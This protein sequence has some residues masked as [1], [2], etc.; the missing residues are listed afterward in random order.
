MQINNDHFDKK[1]NEISSDYDTGYVVE[2]SK[3][4]HK[5]ASLQCG[6]CKICH[7]TFMITSTCVIRKHGVGLICA[8]TDQ[9]LSCI[10]LINVA[11]SPR[12][13]N[14]SDFGKAALAVAS[15]LTRLLLSVVSD[16]SALDAWLALLTFAKSVLR[17]PN[18]STEKSSP[19]NSSI[20][21][22]IKEASL[23]HPN[24]SL[25]SPCTSVIK[26]QKSRILL[27]N[28]TDNCIVE[29]LCRRVSENIEDGDVRGASRTI[30][31]T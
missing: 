17:L 28:S 11:P 3:R 13:V 27:N 20:A 29:S 12:P 7:W 16:S 10:V 15:S 18:D 24:V 4:V 1:T 30:R 23:L 9:P 25:K 31:S 19:V 21:N 8:S 14:H 6:E 5:K 26:F 2:P 22:K